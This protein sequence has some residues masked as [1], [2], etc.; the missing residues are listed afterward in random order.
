MRLVRARRARIANAA[1]RVEGDDG[2]AL[3]HTF[4][5]IVLDD[6]IRPE[7]WP[8]LDLL[9]VLRR[10]GAALDRQVERIVGELEVIA[11]SIGLVDSPPACVFA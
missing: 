2:L 6:T 11:Q 7:S 3:A 4:C 5:D 9:D 8:L 1:R 10:P